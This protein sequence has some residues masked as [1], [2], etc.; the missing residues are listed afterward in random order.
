[1]RKGGVG[2]AVGVGVGVGVGAGV[3]VGVGVGREYIEV[4]R[5]DLPTLLFLPEIPSSVLTVEFQG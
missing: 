4:S 3:G 2:V 1:M 5:A